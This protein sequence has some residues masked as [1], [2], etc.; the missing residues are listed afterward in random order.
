M[1]HHK[2]K[3]IRGRAPKRKRHRKSRRER[4]RRRLVLL[5]KYEPISPDTDIKKF[6]IAVVES[7][8]EDEIHTGT[9]LYE[10]ELKPLTVSDDSL[11]A[12]LHTVNDKAEF[13]KSIQEIIN[14]LC[15]DEL[16]TLHVEAHGAG[17]EGILLSSGEIL[18]WKDFMDSCRILNEVLSGLLIVTLSM[19]NSLPILGCIDPTKR[20]PFKAI[21]LTNRDVT[22]DEVE[23][24]FI[25]FYNNYKNPLDTFKATGAIRDEVNNGV[26]NSSPFHLLV[27]DTIFDWFVDLNRDPNGLAHIVNENFC[28]LKAINPEYTRE[29]TESEIRGFIN[30]LAKN[31]RDYFLYW[32]RIKKSS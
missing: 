12:S 26:E 25:A 2:K 8:S 16:V 19:C 13:E 29:R 14:S 22:V 5:N 7:L 27:A 15:G 11:T 4:K 18:G 21:L 24:G 23:R 6:R 17:E 31:G 3:R 1:A 32:D 20:A 9:K 10:G 30:D 28:R